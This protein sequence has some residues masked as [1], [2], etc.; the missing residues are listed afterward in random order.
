[1]L[2][3]KELDN[4][5]VYVSTQGDADLRVLP[6]LIK[7][8]PGQQILLSI[9]SELTDVELNA[10]IENPLELKGADNLLLKFQAMDRGPVVY[11][12]R[13][14]LTPSKNPKLGRYGPSFRRGKY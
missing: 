5:M 4:G 6:D 10:A 2:K 1:M 12:T 8:Y 3:V 11:Q 7:R 9:G 13:I 14:P